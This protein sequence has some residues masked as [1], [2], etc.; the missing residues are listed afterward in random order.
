MGRQA[1]PIVLIADRRAGDNHGVRSIGVRRTRAAVPPTAEPGIW[2]ISLATA[3]AVLLTVVPAVPTVIAAPVVACP[4]VHVV[5]AKVRAT[6]NRSKTRVEQ[7]R[8]LITAATLVVLTMTTAIQV[9]NVAALP[10]FL[11]VLAVPGG[12]ADEVDE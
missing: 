8:A 2:V 10:V 3:L 12:R 4:A 1:A 9:W 11:R 6:A 7:P 5:A